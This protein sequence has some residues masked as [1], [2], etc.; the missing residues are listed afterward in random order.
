MNLKSTLLLCVGLVCSSPIFTSCNK[1]DNKTYTT[2]TVDNS[3]AASVSF[4]KYGIDAK[5]MSND[6]DLGGLKAKSSSMSII[7]QSDNTVNLECDAKWDGYDI[8]IKIPGLVLSGDY[9]DVSFYEDEYDAKL[10]YNDA[11]YDQLSTM[12]KGS[13]RSSVISKAT[14][15][16]D[17]LFVPFYDCDLNIEFSPDLNNLMKLNIT[18][19]YLV[20]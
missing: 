7:K 17:T 19:A 4:R 2:D 3:I 1:D 18:K 20:E 10:I 16:S 15:V 11:K 12:I 8:S 5:A 9:G 13:I 6:L 14:S